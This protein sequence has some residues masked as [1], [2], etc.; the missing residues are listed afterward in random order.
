M[1]IKAQ[2]L[3]EISV[4]GNSVGQTQTFAYGTVLQIDE[5]IAD[6]TTDGQVACTVDISQLKAVII[7]SDQDV[8]LKTNSDSVP[9]DIFTLLANV[10]LVWTSDYLAVASIFS[11]DITNFYLSNASGST[12]NFKAIFII[13]PTI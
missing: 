12:A 4:G 10:P 11:A 3:A 1:T 8:T 13:D 2:V 6:S 5:A 7:M 9:D